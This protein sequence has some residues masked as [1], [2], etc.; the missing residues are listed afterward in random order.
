MS[1]DEWVMPCLVKI[2]VGW[3]LMCRA[4]LSGGAD[5][6]HGVMFDFWYS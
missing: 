4:A 5:L 2:G 6:C 1:P 3:L